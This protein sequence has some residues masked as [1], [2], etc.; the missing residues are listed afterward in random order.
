MK[1][2]SIAMCALL[3]GGFAEA[4]LKPLSNPEASPEAKTVYRYLGRMYGRAILSGQQESTWVRGNPEDEMEYIRAVSGKLPAIRGLDY[5]AYNGVT[6]RAAAWWARGGIP[7]ICWHWGAPTRG[8]G[9]EASKRT[10]DL[11]EALTPGTALHQAMMADLD[12]TAAELAQLRDAGVPVLWRPF[13]EHNGGWFWW[14]KGG[15]ERFKRLWV[16]M[17]T[18]YTQTHRLNNLIWVFGYASKPDADWY[19][20][21]AYVDI[22]GAD[23]Y[24]PGTQHS[25]FESLAGI[26]GPEIPLC[27]HEC[28]PMPDPDALV[29]D[30][31]PWAWFLTWHTKHL[32]QQNTAE[33]VRKVY[34]HPYVVTLDELPDLKTPGAGPGRAEDR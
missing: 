28:G 10:I 1:H 19:P 33:Q 32:K 25:M 15:A 26:V 13:H 24:S 11:E 12:R 17:Y 31:T 6:E 14:G 3:V 5:I 34:T 29:A 16:L 30:G 7:S 27:Y 23:A 22:A 8:T 4:G 21:D 18:H 20:G 9:Y 2:F